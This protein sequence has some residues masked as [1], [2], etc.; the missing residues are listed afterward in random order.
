MA[1]KYVLDTH[2]LVWYLEGNL[3]LGLNAKAIMDDPSSQLVL[4]LIALAEAAFIVEK[5]RTSIPVVSDL[6]NS[7]QADRRIEVYPITWDIF[8]QS[9]AVTVIPELHDRLIISTALYLRY[10]GHTVSL[11]TKDSIMTTSGLVRI[12]W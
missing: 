4:P 3:R 11:M 5:K 6:L 2:A 1:D 10:L 9:L 7:V 12:I 8:Q